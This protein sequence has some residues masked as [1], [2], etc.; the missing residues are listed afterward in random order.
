MVYVKQNPKH[1]IP[2][3]DEDM[4]LVCKLLKEFTVDEV[5]KKTGID[6]KRIKNKA[7]TKG[8]PVRST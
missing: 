8:W 7:A 6:S 2:W 4:R 1:F 5:S 3:T